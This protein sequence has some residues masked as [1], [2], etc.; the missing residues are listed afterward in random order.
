MTTVSAGPSLIDATPVRALVESFNADDREDVVNLIPNAQ[1][2][3]W[4]ERNV[5]GF[6]CPD[7]TLRRVYYYRWW[8]YRKH[9]KPTPSGT[10]VTEFILPVNHAGMHNSI[11]CAL[12]HHLAE[13]RW[14]RDDRFL[15]EYVRFWFTA[16]NG[17][18]EP[19][20]HAYSS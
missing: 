3:D 1:V 14:L 19:K 20:F 11:S 4:I 9:I 17:K 7:E 10:I 8:C 5:P 2:A 18:P 6:D 12:G 15:D 16:D 13:G